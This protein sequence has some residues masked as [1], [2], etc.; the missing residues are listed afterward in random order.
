LAGRP[1]DD[2]ERVLEASDI[3]RVIGEHLRLKGQGREF[4]G[5]CPFHDDHKPSMRVSPAKQIFKCFSCGAGGDVF[6]F[7]Q[8]YHKMDFR[9][10]LEFLA[11]RAGIELTKF[12]PGPVNTDLPAGPTKQDLYAAASFAAEFFQAILRH[13]QHGEAARA[14]VARRGIS[15]AMVERFRI[16]AAPDRWDGLI[17]ALQGKGLDV[18][19][20]ADAGLVKRRET[21]DGH[22]DALRHRLIFPIQDQIGRLIAFGGRKLRDEDEP[23]YLNSP[24]TRLFN[25]SATLFGLHQASR[26]IQAEKRVIVTEGYT[27]AIAC[28]QAG[29]EF[30]VATLGTALT[31]E[32]AR[33]LRRL[34]DTVV[35]VFDGDE[36]GQRAADRAVAVFLAEAI[37]VKI[38]TLSRFTDA[39]DPDELLKREGGAEVFRAALDGAVDLLDFRFARL[40]EKLRGAGLSALNRAVLDEIAAFK[41]MGLDRVEPLR[42]R[43]IEKRLAQLAGVPESTIREIVGAGRRAPAGPQADA[44]VEAKPQDFARTWPNELI[45]CL[46][47]DG[48]LVDRVPT[49]DRD[50]LTPAAMRSGGLATALQGVAIVID[51]LIRVGEEPDVH[52]V[53]AELAETSDGPGQAAA[54]TLAYRVQEET[55]HDPAKLLEYF[56]A[57]LAKAR[58]Q[59]GLA[60]APGESAESALARMRQQHQQSP[61][62]AVRPRIPRPPGG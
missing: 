60:G 43:L 40:R 34:C 59:R 37:D 5:L 9:E 48:T 18:R 33:V 19:A 26:A 23:K 7:V 14:V 22:Y 17:L 56:Q 25:K 36:A 12:K 46:L 1:G 11:E 49:V 29:F 30:A 52:A 42:K 50:L 20:F 54:S 45:G 55:S 10:S 35:L 16:G 57:T 15:P 27:D 53:L 51:E 61:E 3:V 28:H 8:K 6:T 21:G 13:P 38:A 39:K 31:P 58:E 41:D 32:H 62:G 2:R 47:V 44:N 4:V 24:E